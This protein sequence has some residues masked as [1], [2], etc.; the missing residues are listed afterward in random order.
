MVRSTSEMVIH[1][2]DTIGDVPPGLIGAATTISGSKLYLFGGSLPSA[3]E[4]KPLAHLYELDLELWKWKELISAAA[5]DPVS[6][7]RCFHT[8]DIWKDNLVVCGGLG[9]RGSAK[10]DVQLFNLSTRRWL[11]APRKTRIPTA[12]SAPI[13]HAPRRRHSHLSCV[14]VNRLFIIGGK[15]A[16]GAGLDD[17]CVYDLER[18]EWTTIQRTTYSPSLNIDHALC[19]VPQFHVRTLPWH[20]P[21]AEGTTAGTMKPF[22]CSEL[23]TTGS[24]CDIYLS[25]SDHPQGGIHT[26]THLA[27]GQIKTRTFATN[28]S[29]APVSVRLPS[30]G[31]LGSTLVLA[32]N[33][34]VD[35][36]DQQ[37]QQS[38]CIWTL[39]L[40]A[41]HGHW[42]RIDTG[43]LNGSWGNGYLWHEQ[44]KFFTLGKR[45]LAEKLVD[46]GALGWDA[47]SVLDLEALGVYQPPQLKLDVASQKL[48]LASLANGQHTDFTF[49]CEDGRGIPCQREVVMERWDYL[50]ERHARLS[51][52]EREKHG[53]RI[54]ITITDSSVS[55]AQS[56]AVTM[57]LLQYLYSLALG[58]TLQRAPAVLSHLLII[59][60]EFEIPVLEA[61]VRHAM[62]LALDEVTAE[63]VYEIA[64]SCGCRSLKI[65]CGGLLVRFNIILTYDS[66]SI[67]NHRGNQGAQLEKKTFFPLK[68]GTGQEKSPSCIASWAKNWSR[69]FK[70][71]RHPT[72]AS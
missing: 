12:S 44:N 56:Y 45:A 32:G 65:R 57:A 15:D 51:G 17:I 68:L 63:G 14:S 42:T 70:L 34:P 58:T 37:S 40:T 23:A 35:N 36:T 64:A 50:R 21:C 71:R 33:H 24:P 52:A 39:D 31:I 62:H 46:D 55:F 1:S 38:F 60:T 61:L 20:F 53:K 69:A 5:D 10:N 19:V 2:Y 66:Q 18:K 25:N 49:F 59:S 48:G 54:E 41:N 26:I 22:S 43:E 4:P 27:G 13:T 47:V 67:P 16:S 9:A 6:R 7:A 8:L 72:A 29:N 28:T 11:P 3:S 30:G